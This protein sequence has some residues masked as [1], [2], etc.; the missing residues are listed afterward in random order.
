MTHGME[1][2]MEGA[3]QTVARA[4]LVRLRAGGTPE[5]L[6]HHRRALQADR[7]DVVLSIRVH[8]ERSLSVNRGGAGAGRGQPGVLPDSRQNANGEGNQQADDQAQSEVF[9]Y[10]EK[11][12]PHPF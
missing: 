12:A 7:V 6:E 5:V 10:Q 3:G 1:K 2:G 8:L 4:G 9:L 11:Q